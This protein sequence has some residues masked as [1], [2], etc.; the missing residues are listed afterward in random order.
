MTSSEFLFTSEKGNE[1][2]RE[3]GIPNGYNHIC[4]IALG[5]KDENPPAK[6]RRKDVINYIK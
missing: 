6:P 4:T 2:E 5:Y 1:L 3:L